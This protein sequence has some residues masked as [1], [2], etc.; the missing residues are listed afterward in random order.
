VRV[1]PYVHTGGRTRSQT[2]LPIEALVC[3]TPAASALRLNGTHRSVLELCRVPQSVAEV[4]ARIGVPLAV[5]RVLVD[6]LLAQ[7]MVTVQRGVDESAPD[8]ALMKRVL[9]GLHRL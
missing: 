4:S 8:L 9:A 2:P 6:D 3:A 1:R 5:A 7:R